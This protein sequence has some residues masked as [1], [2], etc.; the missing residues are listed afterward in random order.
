VFRI[1][2]YAELYF[3]MMKGMQSGTL[4]S[5]EEYLHSSYSPDCEYLEGKV[6]ERNV[7]EY[8]HARLQTRLG[9]YLVNHEKEW[10]IRA[11]V[12]QRVQVK[13]YR[14]RV[15]DV[16]VIF[17]EAP[18]ESILT[19]PP[20]LCIEILSPEDRMSEILEG[21]SDYLA[22]GVRY[23]WVLDPRTRR[24]HIYRSDG[25]HEMKDGMLWTSAPDILVP[26]DRLFD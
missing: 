22:F 12:E 5:V 26:L 7:G 1:S 10:G 21:V 8:E 17:A 23:V 16:C 4:V 13:E 11:V 15:P 25:V 24:A 2:C 19:R 9:A 3:G 6:L 18:K 20:M 14:F